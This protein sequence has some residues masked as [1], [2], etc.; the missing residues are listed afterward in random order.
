M[1]TKIL[2][3]VFNTEVE[4]IFCKLIRV[5]YEFTVLTCQGLRM[6]TISA[7]LQFIFQRHSFSWGVLSVYLFFITVIWFRTLVVLSTNGNI[8]DEIKNEVYLHN[9]YNFL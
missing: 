2:N 5:F 4:G 8:D 6:H 7:V 3:C 1:G 9:K